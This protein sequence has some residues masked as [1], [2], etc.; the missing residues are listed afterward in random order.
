M[1]EKRVFGSMPDGQ[2]VQAYSLT[3]TKGTS[4]EILT[5][6]ATIRS[7]K[8]AG[9][10]TIDVV[11]GYDTV[12]DYLADQGYLG[13]TVGRYANRIAKGQFK[14]NNRKH[15]VSTNLQG[16]ALHGGIDGFHNRL[17]QV[18]DNQAYDSNVVCMSLYSEDGDQGFPGNLQVTVLF[19]LDD[20]NCLTI[21]YRAQC[22]Q[23]TL[24]N[25]TQ[26]SYFNLAG[27]DSGVI[28]DQKIKA[29]ASFYTPA[30]EQ[31]IPLGDIKAVAGSAFDLSHELP[32]GTLIDQKDPEIRSASGL[33]HNW[34][35]DGFS[36]D[37]SK[38]NL[39]AVVTEPERGRQLI[40]RTSMPGLQIYTGNFIG[41]LPI[42]KGKVTYSP[43]CGFC[44]ESQF[45]PDSPNQPGFPSPVLKANTAFVSRTSYQ[46]LQEV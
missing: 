11:L 35:V 8:L 12:D 7:W 17:W 16:N 22:D 4:I 27:H 30:D 9:D 3:N 6:G 34:C 15:Q 20:S 37:Q 2:A 46:I 32:F 24:F 33:D 14:L 5:L 38:M 10:K 31:A 21:E 13:R 26:H 45:Y 44:L 39:A 29:Y 40:M 18:A 28:Y 1:I 41:S 19:S 23:D 42:G 43:Y 36:P 25:P